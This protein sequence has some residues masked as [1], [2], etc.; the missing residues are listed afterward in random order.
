MVS[1]FKLV[2]LFMKQRAFASALKF[3]KMP[4]EKIKDQAINWQNVALI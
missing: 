4:G 2:M 3:V 1:G